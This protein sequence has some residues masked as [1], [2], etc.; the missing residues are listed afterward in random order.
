[1]WKDSSPGSLAR[2]RR[3]QLSPESSDDVVKVCTQR[4]SH[5]QEIPSCE[6]VGQQL[7]PSVL[8]HRLYGHFHPVIVHLGIL[9][10]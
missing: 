9:H 2:T 5:L 1:M 3:P 10:L 4:P 7:H 8:S 6:A